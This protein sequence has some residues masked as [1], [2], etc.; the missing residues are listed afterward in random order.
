[1]G[2]PAAAGPAA[3]RRRTR[4]ARR[5]AQLLPGAAGP[6]RGRSLP[7]REDR[8]GHLPRDGRARPARHHHPRS[9]RRR[10]AE[11]RLLRPGGTRGR[12]RRFRLPLDDE[13]AELAGDGADQRLRHRGAEAEVPA[14]AGPRRVDRLLRPDRAEPRQR[15]GQHGHAREEGARRLFAV[16]QQDVDQQL[17]HCRCLRR[18]GQ[19]RRRA[20]PR[21]HPRQ[22]RQGIECPGDPQQGGAARLHH[23]RDRHGR[24]VLPRGK[25][26]SG[27]ARTQRA[28]HLPEQRAL[29]HRL[30]RA[31]RGRRL[32]PAGA[33]VRARP[34]AVRPAAGGQPADPEEAG[35]HADRDHAGAAGLPAPGP[36]EG[37]GHG[38]G[39]SHQPS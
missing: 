3:Q 1:M 38:V 35:R 27:R 19:G 14:Q 16:G 4:G 30:G 20:D 11:L 31:R 7:P 10:R 26:L 2:R 5:R 18:L 33:P 13:R 25:R 12:A 39:G 36:H 17:A 6:A 23:R 29:R 24:G 28:L 21:L 37:R 9:L 22:G 34:Q 15:P 8:P 32:L